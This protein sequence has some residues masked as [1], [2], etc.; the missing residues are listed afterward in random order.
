[1]NLPKGSTAIVCRWVF[2][3]DSEQYKARLVAKKYSQKEGTD[4]NGIFSLIVKHTS[5][6]LL[7]AIVAQGDQVGSA[8]CENISACE[9]EEK[10]YMKQLEVFVQEDQENVSSQVV[11]LWAKAIS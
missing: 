7:L 10:I 11:F 8:G 6:Q 1:V 5:I 2:R 3:N 4:Y 9:P